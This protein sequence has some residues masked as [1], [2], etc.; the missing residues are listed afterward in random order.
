MIGRSLLQLRSAY[1]TL[2]TMG[3]GERLVIFSDLDG[4]LLDHE[5]YSFSA[6]LPALGRLKRLNIPIIL[7]SSKTAAEL[8]RIQEAMGLTAYP[9]IIENGAGLIGLDGDDLPGPDYTAL[10][11]HL[12]G[13]PSDL[14]AG[15]TGFGDM[16]D[17]TVAKVTGLTLSDA[18]MARSRHFSEPGLWSGSAQRKSE[19]LSAL[20]SCGVHAREGGRFLTLS[21][22]HTK[23]SQMDVVK[24]RLNPATTLA[25]GD[26]PNDVEMLEAADYAFIIRNPHRPVLPALPG[27]ASGRIARTKETGPEGWN[28]AVNC[29]LDKWNWD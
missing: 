26:A 5:S 29:L 10:R 28:R 3:L 13:L 9:A 8:H 6:A 20:K 2:A 15:F 25:L 24:A 4:T 18:A 14:R 12:D 21:F 1:Q 16:T 11:Q 19:F 23:A 7:A 17:E 27:E 22:G